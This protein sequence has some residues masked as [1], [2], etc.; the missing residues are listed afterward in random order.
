MNA[1]HFVSTPSVSSGKHILF[2]YYRGFSSFI[3]RDWKLVAAAYPNA[4]L[5]CM[6]GLKDVWRL[7][8]ATGRADLVLCWFGGRHAWW[9]SV[10]LQGRCPFVVIAG[11]WDVANMPEINYG[12]HAMFPHAPMVR[13]LFRR[14]TRVLAV[15]EYAARGAMKYARVPEDRIG[16]IWHG[17]DPEEFPMSKQTRTRDVLT[18]A[19]THS[20][21]KNLDLILDTAALMPD[22]K[23]QVAGILDPSDLIA[24]KGRKLANVE[25]TGWLTKDQLKDRMSTTRVYFQPSSHES[26]GCAVAEA[27]LIGCI[28]VVTR[29]SA[30]PEVVGQA[31]FYLEEAGPHLAVAAIRKALAAPEEAR[32]RARAQIVNNYS[33]EPYRTRFLAELAVLL[34]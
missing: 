13:G 22:L 16:V 6:N 4:E 23:F 11:G 12:A 9:A 10:L 17:F 20:R 1:P 18:V 21:I 2:V 3:E 25:F 14:A 29:T 34:T 26:F 7:G 8:H 33:L 5:F 30:L 28:P 32:E 27:M 31:G 24:F 19:G 15:S